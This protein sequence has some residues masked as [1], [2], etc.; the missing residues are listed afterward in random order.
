MQRI[1]N[2][3][4]HARTMW[5]VAK[6][7]CALPVR[8]KTSSQLMLKT[9]LVSVGRFDASDCSYEPSPQHPRISESVV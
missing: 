9:G 8:A 1:Q 6:L 7:A 4:Q 5:S 3:Q 2:H